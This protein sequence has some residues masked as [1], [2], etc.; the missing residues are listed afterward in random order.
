MNY[1]DS[2]VF[3]IFKDISSYAHIYFTSISK[4]TLVIQM[5]STYVLTRK[6]W[7]LLLPQLYS[8]SKLKVCI[9]IFLKILYDRVEV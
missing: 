3:H 1:P 2:V 8:D 7:N 9:W 5:S 6:Y 4:I